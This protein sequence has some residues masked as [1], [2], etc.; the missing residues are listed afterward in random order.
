MDLAKLNLFDNSSPE[1]TPIEK[2][3]TRELNIKIQNLIESEE[4][5]SQNQE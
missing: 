1:G 4:A 2:S 5:R 3:W